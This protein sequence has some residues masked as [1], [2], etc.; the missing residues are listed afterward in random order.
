MSSYFGNIYEAVTSI[1]A[2]MLVTIKTFFSTPETIQYPEENPIDKD[3]K[4]YKGNLKPI[5][6]RYR[7]FLYLDPDICNVCRNC[8]RICPIDCIQIEDLKGPKIKIPGPG[9]K[10]IVKLRHLTRFDIH[11]ARC[12]FCGLCVEICPQGA[13]VFTREFEGATADYQALIYKFISPE[14]LERVKKII[15]EHQAGAN[16]AKPETAK[17]ED[18]DKEEVEG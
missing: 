11:I 1:S 6:E 15:E 17:A 5:A 18:K 9:S 10:E 3:M 7:G 13:L 8:E 14:E 2:G 12:M 4:T 16:A